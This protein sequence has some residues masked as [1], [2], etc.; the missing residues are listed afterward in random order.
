MSLWQRQEIQILLRNKELSTLSLKGWMATAQQS[1]DHRRHSQRSPLDPREYMR[2]RRERRLGRNLTSGNRAKT[3]ADQHGFALRINNEGHHWMW[4]KGQFVAEWWP[5]SA[6][7][8]LNRDYARSFDAYDWTGVVPFLETKE[9]GGH[10]VKPM[11][12]EQRLAEET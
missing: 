2:Q 9:D 6:K 3:W 7:L 11:P 5:S 4:Q 12:S 10:H 8:V 1:H